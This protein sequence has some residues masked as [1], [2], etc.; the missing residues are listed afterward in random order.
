M[1]EFN[2]GTRVDPGGELRIEE[3][4]GHFFVV[5][6]EICIPA[7][8]RQEAEALLSGIT[9]K[10]LLV[11]MKLFK[12]ESARRRVAEELARDGEEAL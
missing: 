1:I 5:G 6:E 10:G 11:R 4:G 8:T 12:S 3:R 2:D 7:G 9:G